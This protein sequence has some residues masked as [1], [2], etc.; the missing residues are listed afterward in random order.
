MHMVSDE[1]SMRSA[2]IHWAV[3]GFMRT[4]H[5]PYIQAQQVGP[6]CTWAWPAHRHP[7]WICDGCLDGMAS[8][9]AAT[10]A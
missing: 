6:L 2:C 7:S 9:A 8:R 3:T 1:R 4:G 5:I 10:S